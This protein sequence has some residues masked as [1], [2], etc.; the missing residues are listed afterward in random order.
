MM[1]QRIAKAVPQ[2]RATVKG[3]VL[4]GI[5]PMVLCGK[6]KVCARYDIQVRICFGGR[7]N[8]R[9]NRRQKKAPNWGAFYVSE[10]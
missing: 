8:L 7:G 4:Y 10:D 5:S 1:V 2:S 6:S 3:L 9:A